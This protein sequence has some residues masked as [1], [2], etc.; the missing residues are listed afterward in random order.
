[1][2]YVNAPLFAQE[3]G[4]TVELATEPVSENFRNVVTLVAATSAGQQIR[5]AGTVT[6][7]KDVQKLTEIDGYDLEMKL[8]DHLVVFKYD[9][10]PGVIGLF[11]RALGNLGINIE[12]M[13]VSPKNDQALAVLA[14]DSEVTAEVVDTVASE[15]GASFAKVANIAED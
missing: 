8:T 2:S 14:V 11:G 13:Q 12:A 9:D 7:P 3:R 4:V 1:V 6:G 15:I 10:R 5:V